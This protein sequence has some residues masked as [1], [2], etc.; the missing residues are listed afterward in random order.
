MEGRAGAGTRRGKKKKYIY[1]YIYIY[2]HTHIYLPGSRS[3]F[4]ALA[5]H[6]SFLES[7]KKILIIWVPVA[8]ISGL[9]G[10]GFGNLKNFPGD[11][12]TQPSLRITSLAVGENTK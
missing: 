8:E 10:L 5:E 9:I 4:S 3:A 12:T 6:W 1:I 2:T 11:S 7:L